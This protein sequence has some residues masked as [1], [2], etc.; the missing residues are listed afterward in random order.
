ME[1]VA[2]I[3][4]FLHYFIRETGI[5]LVVIAVGAMWA[6]SPVRFSRLKGGL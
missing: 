6:I 3:L 1:S 5:G 4:R 2:E